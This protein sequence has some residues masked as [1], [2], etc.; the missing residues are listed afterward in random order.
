MK[1]DARNGSTSKVSPHVDAAAVSC[2]LAA[3][4]P[5]QN[6]LMGFSKVRPALF[7]RAELEGEITERFNN[8]QEGKIGVSR[9]TSQFL[10]DNMFKSICETGCGS[11]KYSA[12]EIN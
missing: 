3:K 7:F 12:G 1:R 8:T 10:D 11:N 5:S 2:S 6:G 4:Y 9:F